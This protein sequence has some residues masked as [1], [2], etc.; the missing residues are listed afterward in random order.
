MV[1]TYYHQG[2]AMTYVPEINNPTQFAYGII[3]REV[4]VTV[5]KREPDGLKVREGLVQ[6]IRPVIGEVLEKA[7]VTDDKDATLSRLCEAAVL[8]SVGKL[9]LASGFTIEYGQQFNPDEVVR[10]QLRDDDPV[11]RDAVVQRQALTNE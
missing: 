9:M 5:H 11:Y 10:V 2:V 6:L 4:A 7:E 8:A 1:N 3:G